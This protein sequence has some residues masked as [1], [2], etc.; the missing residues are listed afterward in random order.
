M[1]LTDMQMSGK[2]YL[3]YFIS[4]KYEKYEMQRSQKPEK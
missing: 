1:L 4:N 3:T 2:V